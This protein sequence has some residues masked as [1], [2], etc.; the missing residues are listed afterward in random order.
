MFRSNFEGRLT[1]IKNHAQFCLLRLAHLTLCLGA[2]LPPLSVSTYIYIRLMSRS[3]GGLDVTLS[4]DVPTILVE[5][6]YSDLRFWKDHNVVHI[7]GLA[8]PNR[9]VGCYAGKDRSS[10]VNVARCAPVLIG[11][12]P[13]E[14]IL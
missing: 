5:R 6:I 4:I 9:L 13:P 14:Q 7:D 11:D 1:E 3:F 12:G 8:R 2:N 10:A